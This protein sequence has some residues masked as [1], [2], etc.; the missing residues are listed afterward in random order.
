MWLF[1][2][3]GLVFIALGLWQSICA[4]CRD[5]RSFKIGTESKRPIKRINFQLRRKRQ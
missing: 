3:V 5:N 4:K 2:A 1:I